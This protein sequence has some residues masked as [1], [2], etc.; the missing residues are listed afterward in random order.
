LAVLVE[1][2]LEAEESSRIPVVAGMAL[3]LGLW[4]MA[5]LNMIV[6]VAAETGVDSLGAA[7]QDGPS[8]KK[9]FSRSLQ[10]RTDDRLTGNPFWRLAG[11][12]SCDV[13]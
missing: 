7:A 1:L 9:T 8:C 11:G 5:D 10:G 12:L 13:S 6:P 3:I 4:G 2:V